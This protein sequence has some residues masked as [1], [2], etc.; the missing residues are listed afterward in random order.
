MS[1]NRLTS[2]FC[3]SRILASCVVT[4]VS[5]LFMSTICLPSALDSVSFASASSLAARACF[6]IS[7]A[8]AFI[9]SAS[10][11]RFR[12]DSISL[13]RCCTT[14]AI[15]FFCSSRFSTA[16]FTSAS[17]AF[18]ASSLRDSSF[19]SRTSHRMRSSSRTSVCGISLA[20]CSAAAAAATFSAACWISFGSP[21]F[22]ASTNSSSASLAAATLASCTRAASSLRSASAFA[23]GVLAALSAASCTGACDGGSRASSRAAFASGVFSRSYR[24]SASFTRAACSAS[25]AFSISSGSPFSSASF[26]GSACGAGAT[27]STRSSTLYDCGVGVRPSM[28]ARM[29]RSD[30]SAKYCRSSSS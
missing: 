1:S 11:C 5:F 22:L 10:C 16:F 27:C 12:S 26:S 20:G 24:A 30:S 14:C 2:K 17:T 7:A 3:C 18:L 8:L 25:I 23:S 9:A 21:D 15:F 4:S 13:R 19:C 29:R 28:M 6:I